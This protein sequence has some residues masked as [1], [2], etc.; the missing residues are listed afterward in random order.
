LLDPALS[1]HINIVG[2]T[3]NN[4]SRKCRKKIISRTQECHESEGKNNWLQK[5][6]EIL[7][8]QDYMTFPHPSNA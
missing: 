3:G 1:H 6:T 5:L 7:K 4:S 2:A 8:W